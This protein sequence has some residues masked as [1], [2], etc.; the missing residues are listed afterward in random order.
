MHQTRLQPIPPSPTEG[1][2]DPAAASKEWRAGLRSRAGLVGILLNVNQLFNLH[3]FI[4]KLMIDT[5]YYYLLAG[6]F[7]GLS[8]LIY[9]AHGRAR[10]THIP[11]YDWVAVRP[12]ARRDRLACL[13][14]RADRTGGLGHPPATM[15][16]SSPASCRSPSLSAPINFRRAVLLSGARRRAA[17]RRH[18]AVRDLRVLLRYPLFAE[19][20][21]GFHVGSA[22]QLLDELVLTARAWH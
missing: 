14:R 13:E 1:G 16:M 4:G 17:R 3:F 12:D 20:M 11:W 22:K 18:G 15:P 19:S 7:L 9:P 6:L 21:P 2:A 5:S 10:N 8:F